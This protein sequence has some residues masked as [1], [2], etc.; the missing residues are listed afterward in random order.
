MSL[1]PR[2]YVK[3][4]TTGATIAGIVL[5]IQAQLGYT[6]P[7]WEAAALPS[8]VALLLAYLVPPSFQEKVDMATE[9]VIEVA[10]GISRVGNAQA[11]AKVPPKV[12]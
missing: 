5:A 9:E 11:S 12:P 10:Q 4:G 1:A 8:I 7:V 2:A 6:P 3:A